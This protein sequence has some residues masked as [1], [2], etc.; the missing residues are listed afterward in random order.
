MQCVYALEAAV[1]ASQEEMVGWRSS[2]AYTVTET[3]EL[4]KW[5]FVACLWEN[6]QKYL[7]LGTDKSWFVH[8]L[9]AVLLFLCCSF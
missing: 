1:G 2:L 6:N 7:L 9:Y 5:K 3:P 8:R 4:S